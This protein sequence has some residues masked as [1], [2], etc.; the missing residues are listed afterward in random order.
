MSAYF[1]LLKRFGWKM[2]GSMLLGSLAASIPMVFLVI[3]MIIGI[4]AIGMTSV[5]SSGADFFDDP[6][7]F[8]AALFNP[9][10]IIMTILFFFLFFL[11]T[12]LTSA[13][14]SAGS[15]GVVSEAIQEDRAT[16]GA[17]FR[18]GFRRL[19]PMLGL[20]LVLFLLAIPP[21]I[22]FVIAIFLFIV[23]EAWSIVLGII[24]VLLTILAYIVYTLIVFH[25]PT[26]LIAEAQGVFASIAASF[27]AFQKRFGEVIISG[28]I[29]L[30]ISFIG[31]IFILLLDFVISGDNLFNLEAQPNPFR[32]LLSNILLFPINVGLQ[33]VITY[34][35]AFRYLRVIKTPPA[36]GAPQSDVIDPPV[37]HPIPEQTEE[38]PQPPREP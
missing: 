34:T 5:I 11:F 9:G 26:I 38:T 37:H 35:L 4:V 29:I 36:G 16:I 17:Y 33:L 14:S 32:S 20:S 30:A 7:T 24:C 31:G 18:Y 12:L 2:W 15:I 6:D 3:I 23:G 22:P 8:L 10:T 28:L 13:F 19:F 27:R 1:D 21:A 25:A